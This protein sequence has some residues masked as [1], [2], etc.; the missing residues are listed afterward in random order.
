MNENQP[1]N[2]SRPAASS[3]KSGKLSASA[4]KQKKKK[5]GRVS[6]FS[7]IIDEGQKYNT[8]SEKQPVAPQ[9]GS[10]GNNLENGDFTSSWAKQSANEFEIIETTSNSEGVLTQDLAEINLDEILQHHNDNVKE[11]SSSEGSSS[12]LTQEGLSSTT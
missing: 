4:R 10:L 5:G 12:H 8:K 7:K 6:D 2:R 9:N 11:S 3:K 1:S